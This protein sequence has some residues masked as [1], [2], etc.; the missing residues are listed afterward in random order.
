MQERC[1]IARVVCSEVWVCLQR[2][3]RRSK[4]QNKGSGCFIERDTLQQYPDEPRD[5][6]ESFSNS[7]HHLITKS[8]GRFACSSIWDH[9]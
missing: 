9:L 1:E 8:K 5:S 2:P 6:P 3:D 4:V 7:V